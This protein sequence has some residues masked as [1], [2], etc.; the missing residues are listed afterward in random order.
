MLAMTL[1]A[2][3]LQVRAPGADPLLVAIG[4][5]LLALALWVAGEALAG[6]ARAARASAGPPEPTAG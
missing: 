3:W 2:L 5:V 6:V 1:W 4:W